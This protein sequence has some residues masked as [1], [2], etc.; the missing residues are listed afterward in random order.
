MAELYSTIVM[1][2]RRVNFDSPNLSQSYVC[3]TLSS[4]YIPCKDSSCNARS[5]LLGRIVQSST[6]S[7]TKSYPRQTAGFHPLLYD[8]STIS[9]RPPPPRR[10]CS[11]NKT[12]F[13]TTHITL[14]ICEQSFQLAIVL[15]IS[16]F[17]LKRQNG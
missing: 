14:A 16:T 11:R 13:R 17:S 2:V 15:S 7:F 9:Y 5:C 12:F 1:E 4:L 6:I 8:R 3:I 10:F